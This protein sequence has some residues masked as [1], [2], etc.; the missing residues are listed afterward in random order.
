M[1]RIGNI[2]YKKTMGTKA[3]KPKPMR[4]KRS[5]IKSQKIIDRNLEIL[6]KIKS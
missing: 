5:G 1:F 6:K 4:S 3:K 2:Y